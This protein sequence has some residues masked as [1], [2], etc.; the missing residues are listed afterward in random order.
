[1]QVDR[2]PRVLVLSRNYP[3][4]VQKLLGMWERQIVAASAEICD[5]KV[6]AP[7]P[8]CPPLPGIPENYVR[9]RRI[10]RHQWDDGV[11]VFR[12]RFLVGLGGSLW[13]A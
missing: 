2:R 3:N 13:A 8:W 11:E 4:D 7:V 12:P 9:F 6:V 5:P 1:M 10:A